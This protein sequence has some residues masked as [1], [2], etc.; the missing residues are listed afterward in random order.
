MEHPTSKSKTQGTARTASG[1]GFTL[2]ELL[3]VIAIIAILAAMLLP[4]LGKAKEKAKRTGCLN[5]LKQLGLGC[6]MYA[7]DYNGHFFG[8]GI[9]TPGVRV[10]GDD[11]LN[12]LHP[13][14]IPSRNSFVCTSTQ[15]EVRTNMTTAATGEVLVTDLINNAPN[16][17]LAGNGH[18]YETLGIIY[19]ERKT[20]NVVNTWVLKRATGHIGERP[21]PS[22]IWLMMDAD[23][24]QPP[25]PG[26]Y[27]NY[28]DKADNHG[29]D[30]AQVN[31]ADGHAEWISRKK[32]IDGMNIARDVAAVAP[33]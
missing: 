15:N 30:G 29:A 33:Y 6:V 9:G 18:S 13:Q 21:G 1:R 17:R 27:G 22:A 31:F 5:N 11:N 12:W 4:A 8:D 14:Y 24:G 23:D 26:A 7:M 2:I 28:P 32:F 20:E 3:V 16:G 19:N 25:G 10:A